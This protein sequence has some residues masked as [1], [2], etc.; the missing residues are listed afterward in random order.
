MSILS[1]FNSGFDF[2]SIDTTA[3][4]NPCKQMWRTTLHELVHAYL[5]VT[6]SWKLNNDITLYDDYRS[7]RKHHGWDFCWLLT[8]VHQRA[9]EFLN[10]KLLTGHDQDRIS[11][12]EEWK[13]IYRDAI[14]LDRLRLD[15]RIT[16]IG[17]NLHPLLADVIRFRSRSAYYE[18]LTLGSSQPGGVV[19]R[20]NKRGSVLVAALLMFRAIPVPFLTIRHATKSP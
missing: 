17:G 1:A 2:V 9:K 19:R 6:S 11:V 20:E 4:R 14:M 12:R 15:R 3:K 7:F 8:H 13:L 16:D 5:C 10:V 18:G